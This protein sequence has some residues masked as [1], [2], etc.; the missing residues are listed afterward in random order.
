MVL[1]RRPARQRQGPQLAFSSRNATEDFMAMCDR[2]NEY[3]PSKIQKDGWQ[4]RIPFK[5]SAVEIAEDLSKAAIFAGL[6]DCLKEIQAFEADLK[7]K[8][9]GCYSSASSDKVGFAGLPPRKPEKLLPC[10]LLQWIHQNGRQSLFLFPVPCSLVSYTFPY[11]IDT[12]L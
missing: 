9:E 11:I 5:T 7:H 6:D 8:L 10:F 1:R 12:E 4:W 2:I 3:Y